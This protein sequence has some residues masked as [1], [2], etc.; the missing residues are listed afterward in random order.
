MT[1]DGDLTD[2]VFLCWGFAQFFFK[3]GTKLK[4]AVSRSVESC[5]DAAIITQLSH[6]RSY[7]IY[8]ILYLLFIT[9]FH[10]FQNLH[11]I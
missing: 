8:M 10:H 9:K 2:C 4:K 1:D 6:G 3:V 7:T 5:M 11:T